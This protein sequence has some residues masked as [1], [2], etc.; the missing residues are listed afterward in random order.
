MAIFRGDGGAGDSNT[1]ATVTAVTEQATIATTKA[2][3]AADSATAAGI[4]AQNAATSATASSTSSAASS[5]YAGEAAS[6][7]NAAATSATNAATSATEASASATA[8]SLAE[9]NA[10]TAETNAETS[11]SNAAASAATATTQATEAATSATSASTSASTATTK[12]SEAATS[13]SNAA[14]SESNAATSAT[15]AATSATASST[16]ATASATSASAASTSATNASTSATEAATSETNAATSATAAASSATDS[17]NSATTATTQATNAAT[18]ASSASASAA[19]ATTKASEAATSATNAATSATTA[20]TKASEAS[21]SATNAATS[22]TN[23]AA[24]FDSFDDRYL[25]AKATAPTTDNDGDALLTGALYFDT[26]TESMKVWSGS[27]W[28]DAYAT[29][30]GALLATNNLS[31]LNNV[32]TSRSNLGLGTAAVTDSTAYATAA[33]GTTADA[34]LPRTGGAMTGAITTNSTFDGRDVSAD[35]AKLD[36]IETGADVTDAGNVEAAGALMDAELT[37]IAAV[38]ALDQGVSTTDSPTF[39]TVYSDGLSVGDTGRVYTQVLINSSFSGESELRMGDTDTDAGSI[40]YRN[41]TD[42]MTIRAAAGAR[43]ALDATGVDV[44]GTV[45]AT[46]GNSTEWNTAYSWGDHGTEGYATQTYVGTQISNLVDSAPATLDTLNELAAAL[47]D[48]PNF[49]TTVTNS[50][51]T[52]LPLAGGA[53]T[54][55]ITTNSTFDGRDVSVDGT[56]LDGI[57]ANANNYVLPFTDNS[58]NWNTAYGW[59][60][61]ASAGY[62]PS[63][64][65]TAA[66]VL[67]KIKTVDGSGSGLDADLLDGQQGSYYYAASNPSGYTSNVGDITGV[68]AGTGLSGGGTSGTVTL[69]LSS[70][71]A[72]AVATELTSAVDLDTLN[73]AQAGFYYQTANADTAGN[74]YPNGL[75]GSLIVQKSAGNATQ[76]YQTYSPTPDLFFRSNYN[77]GYGSWRKIWNSGNDGSGSGLDA[78]LLDGQHG[79]YYYPASNPNGYTNDQ[80]AAEILTAI[81]TV[82]GAGSG[83]DADLLD[84]QQGSYYY[85]ASNPNG[86][87]TNTGTVTEGGTTFNNTYPLTVRTS[88]N[89]IFSHPNITFTGST[90]TLNLTAGKYATTANETR[91]NTPSG[92]IELGPKN[93]SYAHIYTDRPNFYFNKQIRVLGNEVWHTGNDGSGSG[94]DADLL[95]GQHGSYYYSSANIPPKIEAGGSGPSTENLNTVADSVSVGQLEYRG[96]NSSSSNAPPVSDNANGVIT[97]GQHGGNYNAQLAFSSSGNMYWRDNPGSSF[98]SWREVWDSGNDGSGSGLDADTVDGIQASSFLRSDADDTMTGDLL[99]DSSN[100][101]INIKSG[102]GGTSGAVNWTFSTTGTNYASIKLP[103]DTRASTGLWIDSGYPISIDATTRINFDISGVRKAAIDSSGHF[104]PEGRVYVQGSTTNYLSQ[105]PYS[106]TNLGINFGNALFFYSGSTNLASF[107][108]TTSN[109]TNQLIADK[110]AATTGTASSTIISRGSVVTTTGYNPQNYHIT[111]QN[112]ANVTKG[113]ISSSH[114]ATIYSTSSDYRLKEDLQ[115]ISNATERLLAL[116]PVNFKWID[117]QERS[118]GFIA[119]ELQEHLPEAVT[120]EKDAT[121]EVTET[122]VAEDGTETEV[123]TTVPEMQG[124]D[125]SKLVPLLVK[126]IQELEARIAALEE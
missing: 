62:L 97:V 32:T 15:S 72:P 67:T 83:L 80:T 37:N 66:D 119:H 123:T 47:G 55:P 96:F 122:V 54:G 36:T 98:G 4:S 8:A 103:Y 95:D 82:D 64:S 125:Q 61:H 3:E 20:T 81:K 46:G 69:N 17:A 45:T 87:T 42:T 52:K 29:L 79:S 94:L 11:E 71:M 92:Y 24:S 5:T 101:E 73:A 2:S 50:I 12:A 22:E 77:T 1:D 111:F 116:N 75:A 40:S 35:G 28:L 49:A 31:D 6:S 7:A 89:V 70:T 91:F 106:S 107:S 124:I 56:K 63:S 86:Y 65:Y 59:G 126:T 34:A 16:S 14:T 39:N 57:A 88:A 105:G 41:L 84:G 115:P 112:G 104:T 76:L 109:F 19:T 118:D 74:N 117:G 93:T 114:Y 78:D 18:S 43:M 33:Q 21:T 44:T 85:P 26:S 13:A 30:S 100:A 99:M 27:S 121:T 38:K 10:E 9:T 58:T 120:G 102:T 68:T 113:S 25:G 48:D 23:A 110:T 53:M 51:A 90:G 108:T 60:D